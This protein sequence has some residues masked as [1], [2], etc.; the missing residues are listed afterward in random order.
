MHIHY[1]V[2]GNSIIEFK[3]SDGIHNPT[4]VTWD[5]GYDDWTSDSIHNIIRSPEIIIE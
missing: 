2:N 4:L 1:N 5:L 3:Y